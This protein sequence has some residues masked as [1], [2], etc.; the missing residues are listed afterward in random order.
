MSIEKNDYLGAQGSCLQVIWNQLTG[1][2]RMTSDS[3]YSGSGARTRLVALERKDGTW[4]VFEKQAVRGYSPDGFSTMVE[5]DP[6]LHHKKISRDEA[7]K[8][9]EKYNRYIDKQSSDRKAGPLECPF[10]WY[11]G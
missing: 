2:H 1:N 5:L 11:K 7:E 3:S 9:I 4:D 10:F 8:A 6:I